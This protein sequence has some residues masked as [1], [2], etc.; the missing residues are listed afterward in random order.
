MNKEEIIQKLNL[1][2]HIEGGYFRRTYT[3][4]QQFDLGSS[5][6]ALLSSI[7]YL[8]TDDSPIGHLHKNQSD[9]MHYFHSGSP[10]KFTLISPQGDLQQVIVGQAL[11]C[12]QQLQ[13]LVPG[14]YWKASELLEGEYALIS[15]AVFPGFDYDDMQMAS[16]Q[17]IHN[18]IP[19]HY[20][21][22]QHLISG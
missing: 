14:G 8:L 7:Y 3:S 2:S 17:Q 1:T 4:E 21:A 10:I 12:S 15:E 5:K 18:E 11:Q 20:S 19:E 22:L 6:R 9:I 16:H 13:L